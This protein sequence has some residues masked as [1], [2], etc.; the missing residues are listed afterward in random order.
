[1]RRVVGNQIVGSLVNAESD[2]TAAKHAWLI[3]SSLLSNVAW[4]IIFYGVALVIAAFLAGATRPATALRRWLAPAFN[5]RLGVVSAAVA[6]LF[7]LLILWGP[8]PALQQWW[9]ILLA[10]ALIA[11][12]VWALRRETLQEFPDA[13]TATQWP[14]MRASWNKMR[15]GSKGG[16]SEPPAPPAPSA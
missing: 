14:D 3:G 15:G 1:M 8:T 12:G 13:G 7:L 2:K 6:F 5:G 9:G 4:A 11:L 16:G 10:A